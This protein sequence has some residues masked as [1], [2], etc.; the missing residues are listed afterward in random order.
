MK[1]PPMCA[2][3]RMPVAPADELVFVQQEAG[4]GPFSGQSGWY[5]AQTHRWCCPDGLYA[6]LDDRRGCCGCGRKMAQRSVT[7]RR[8]YCTNACRQ[9]HYRERLAAWQPYAEPWQ[10]YRDA[11]ENAQRRVTGGAS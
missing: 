6:D 8:R 1:G 5:I 4:A 11:T 9:R 10:T 7:R 3:C 2:V